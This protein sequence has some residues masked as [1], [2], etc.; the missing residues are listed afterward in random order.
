M[1]S[2][3]KIIWIW[4]RNG[5][6]KL[7][8]EKCWCCSLWNPSRTWISEIGAP[9]GD[10]IGRSGSKRKVYLESWIWETELVRKIAQTNC[11][12]IE[13][14]RWFF[15]AETDSSTIEN[16]WTLFAADR[17]SFYCESALDSDSGFSGQGEFLERHG[18]IFVMQLWIVPRSQSTHES[19]WGVSTHANDK[20]VLCVR[21]WKGPV[22]V[23]AFFFLSFFLFFLSFLSFFLSFFLFFLSFLS[24]FLSLSLSPRFVP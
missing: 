10:S 3:E 2:S 16:W 12:L 5:K 15:C 13:E 22:S 20:K 18:R 4:G 1:C 8:T 19:E 17:E 6:K 9:S 21:L 23:G 14:L 24:F 11:Q 7:G